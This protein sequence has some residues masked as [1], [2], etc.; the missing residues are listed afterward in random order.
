MSASAKQ[1]AASREVLNEAVRAQSRARSADG[2]KSEIQGNTFYGIMFNPELTP[3]QK[4]AEVAKALAFRGS[5]EESRA[6]VKEFESFKEYLQSVREEM[7]TRI[8]K[9]TNTAAFSE[10]QSVYRDLNQRLL[11]FDERMKPLTDI[12]DALYTL[13]TNGMTQEAFREI[14]EDRKRDAELAEAIAGKQEE[15]RLLETQVATLRHENAILSTQRSFFGLGGVKQSAREQM[16]RN[17]SDIE[18]KEAQA[19]ALAAEMSELQQ[20]RGE[21]ASKL[22]EFAA[23]KEK[24]RE[25]LDISS[26]EHVERQKELVAAALN[27]VTTGKERIGSVRVHLDEMIKQVENL[28]DANSNMKQVYAIL[29]DA[30][31]DAEAENQTVRKQLE[32]AGEESMTERM[33]RED[34][35]QNLESHMAT[36]DVS[37]VDTLSTFADLTS[38]EI[39]IRNMEESA[40]NQVD[41]ARVMHTRGIAGV[42]DRLSVV[43]QAVSAAALG[44]SSAMAKETLAAMAESTNLVAQKDSIRVAMGRTEIN[45]D[46]EKALEDLAAYGE[47]QR[48]ATEIS[49]G[50]I[51]EMRQNLEA[52][53]ELAESVDQESK[54]AVGVNADVA[55]GV[56]NSSGKPAEKAGATSPFGF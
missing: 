10:L 33:Q 17:A 49:R 16:A 50:A 44:E 56:S 5:K 46:L 40:K 53:K 21:H 43:L 38:Q 34:K 20:K 8:I 12:T 27:F 1:S 7:A 54:Q 6:A 19:K 25:L 39:R 23:Q 35:K 48:E 51:Q 2:A 55:L 18:Q 26:D 28:G 36:L 13:R 52:L 45:A 31:K 30:I 29:G 47:V 9:L 14:V 41:K 37:S 24:L 22:G 32:P 3:E 4:K 15:L 42:A 11:D